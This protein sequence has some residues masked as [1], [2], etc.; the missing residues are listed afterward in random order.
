VVK[1]LIVDN[2]NY[3]TGAATSIS[4]FARALSNEF[5]FQWAVTEKISDDDL[6]G[7]IADDKYYRF[8]FVELSKKPGRLAAYVPK[9][10]SNAIKLNR[11]IK[12]NEIA[13]LHVNDLYNMVGVAVRMLNRKVKIVYHVRLLRTSYVGSLYSFFLKRIDGAANAIICCSN[14]VLRDVGER[15][16]PTTVIYDSENFK[17]PVDPPVLNGELKNVLYIGNILPGKG[18]DLA[19]QTIELL[20]ESGLD[21]Y[22]RFVGKVDDSKVSSDFKDR[23]DRMISDAKLNGAVEFVGFKR[24]LASEIRNADLVLNL[25]ES[26]SFSMVCLEALKA[27]VPLV[28]SDCGGPAEIVENM[29]SGWLVPNRDFRAAASAIEQLQKDRKLRERFTIEGPLRAR[30]KF[31]VQKNGR[32]L[33]NV[34]FGDLKSEF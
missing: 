11:I 28:A 9:L 15:R 8:K 24:D 17:D 33:R 1:I 3:V 30:S 26:E 4:R 20:R 34:Y 2:S 19:I 22:L 27:G 21:I 12:E 6:K 29:K 10:I 14:A 18:H 25:S 5:E 23:L 16:V 31:D 13:V 32:L 7:F